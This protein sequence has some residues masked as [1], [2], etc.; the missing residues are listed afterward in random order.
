[1]RYW[2]TLLF[3]FNHCQAYAADEF[4]PLVDETEFAEAPAPDPINPEARK[5]ILQMRK[6][7]AEAQEVLVY[8]WYMNDD[9][10]LTFVNPGVKNIPVARTQ[11][12]QDHLC[13]FFLNSPRALTPKPEKVLWEGSNY[14]YVVIKGGAF[15][16]IEAVAYNNPD[17]NYVAIVTRFDCRI[18]GLGTPISSRYRTK[19]TL[20][21][22]LGQ[23]EIVLIRAPAFDWHQTTYTISADSDLSGVCKL[24]GYNTYSN[25]Q[26]AK[27]LNPFA[28]SVKLDVN[29]RYVTKQGRAYG[30]LESIQCR[31]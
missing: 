4:A 29:G 21:R 27:S 23:E 25:A 3:F 26:P 18:Q 11:G 9:G 1:M 14:P 24:Y 5:A 31:N 22:G 30:Y 13:H 2:L 16:Q 17:A 19:E 7:A 10:T 15:D 8:T 12:S 20:W 28:K 6:K